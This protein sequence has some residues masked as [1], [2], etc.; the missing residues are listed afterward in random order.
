LNKAV[1]SDRSITF[2]EKRN[3]VEKSTEVYE[4]NITSFRRYNTFMKT[5]EQSGV[6]YPFNLKLI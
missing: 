2:R 6:T 4:R 3:F 5:E 1:H